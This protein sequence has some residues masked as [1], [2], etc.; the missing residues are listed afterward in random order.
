MA[1]FRNETRERYTV[2]DNSILK[3]K[4]LSLV[5]RGMLT[6]LLSLPDNW[7]FSEEG[8]TKILLDKKPTIKKA[9]K[10]LE[11]LGYLKRTRIRDVQGKLCK[12]EYT[13]YEMPENTESEPKCILPT[14]VSPTMVKLPQYNTNIIK[15]YNNK[16]NY[17][18]EIFEKFWSAYPKKVNKKRTLE[19]F[20]RHRPDEN[21][22]DI[23]LKKLEYFK[24][25]D[26]WTK[27][28]GQF[29]PHPT[30][31]L[32]GERWLDD[33][34]DENTERNKYNFVQTGENSFKL[35]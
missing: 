6:T 29:I 13:V 25:T 17:N 28:N 2:V 30:T 24:K 34:V 19:W 3:N 4:Q 18:K 20:E 27:Q 32:N 23:M 16:R 31:W 10:E 8:L 35:C 21:T 26:N 12:I 14:T 33:I 11:S 5:A 9:L 1:I 7:E 22:V 15:D